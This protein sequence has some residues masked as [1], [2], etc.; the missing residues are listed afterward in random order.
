M[1]KKAQIL[2]KMEER[3]DNQINEN[4][5]NFVKFHENKPMSKA[6]FIRHV[7][8]KTCLI[9]QQGTDRE[10]VVIVRKDLYVSRFGEK[11]FTNFL[12]GFQSCDK[13]QTHMHL[14]VMNEE[15]NYNPIASKRNRVNIF[16]SI[17]SEVHEFRNTLNQI[18]NTINHDKNKYK[19]VIESEHFK[20]VKEFVGKI[21][22]NHNYDKIRNQ[23]TFHNADEKVFKKVL[24]FL[25]DTFILAECLATG[26]SIGSN[27]ILYNSTNL[28]LQVLKISVDEFKNLMKETLEIVSK[29]VDAFQML[30][31]TINTKTLADDLI[32]REDVKQDVKQ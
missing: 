11:L 4:A 6:E 12:C 10:Q 13:I 22:D 19:N 26:Q 1:T 9:N 27:N 20:S 15:L 32:H 23:I 18:M 8:D 5:A 2:L 14:N 28:A 24:T 17:V 25:P 3:L 16:F 21:N 31:Y 7:L 29:G 30:Y